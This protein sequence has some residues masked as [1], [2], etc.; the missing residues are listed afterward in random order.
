MS[1]LAISVHTRYETRR[2]IAFSGGGR[3]LGLAW[4]MGLRAP[5]NLLAQVRD[6]SGVQLAACSRVCLLWCARF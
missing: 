6:L 4:P 2:P 3:V 5:K 1:V